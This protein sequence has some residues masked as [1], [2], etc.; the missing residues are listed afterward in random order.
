LSRI[1]PGLDMLIVKRGSWRSVKPK[2]LLYEM[3]LESKRS[4][5]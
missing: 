2:A 3:L 1:R 4:V 5:F